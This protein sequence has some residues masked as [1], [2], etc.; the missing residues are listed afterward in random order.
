MDSDPVG[1][2]SQLRHYPYWYEGTLSTWPLTKYPRIMNESIGRLLGF[3]T[4]T[5]PWTGGSLK[6]QLNCRGAS[7][8]FR[9]SR[10]KYPR[11]VL[12]ADP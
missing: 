10:P 7:I 4:L 6:A 1:T 12:K 3:D 5:L 8:R 11:F 9:A 2:R